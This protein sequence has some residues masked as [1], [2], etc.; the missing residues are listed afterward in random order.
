MHFF[1]SRIYLHASH[2][3]GESFSTE[4]IVSTNVSSREKRE[5]HVRLS[6]RCDTKEGRKEALHGRNFAKFPRQRGNTLREDRINYQRNFS[7]MCFD[8]I[9]IVPVGLRQLRT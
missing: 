3:R 6:E 4:E 1:Y 2:F 7:A 5:T 8:R 9:L